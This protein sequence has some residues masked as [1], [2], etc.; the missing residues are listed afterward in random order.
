MLSVATRQ[1]GAM[2]WV[3]LAVGGTF[4][5]AAQAFAVTGAHSAPVAAASPAN[6]LSPEE[7][8][9]GWTLLFNGT[10]LSGWRAIGEASFLTDW[11]VR[12]S[13][14][15]YRGRGSGTLLSTQAF[16]DFELIMEWKV[17]RGDDAGL[18]LRV[19]D[20]SRPVGEVAPE[21][22]LI[23]NRGSTLAMEPKRSAG[24]CSHLYAPSHDA[25]RP[26]GEYNLLRVVAAGT[27]V[28]HWLNG[29]KVLEYQIGGA[30]WMSRLSRSPMKAHGDLGS[31]P[32]GYL[33]LQQADETVRFRTIKIRPLGEAASLAIRNPVR[34]R[35]ASAGLPTLF[36]TRQSGLR[37]VMGRQAIPVGETP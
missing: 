28:E 2:L 7:E 15:A 26:Q 32:S 21:V 19:W 5:Q 31:A 37:D 10:D 29:A 20:E 13:A 23:D 14:I 3:G 33:G 9:S 18:F 22:Q 6:M 16:S 4:A 30:D 8:E 25:S 35:K 17:G 27:R 11:H 36:F 12:D 24:A 1:L 34:V